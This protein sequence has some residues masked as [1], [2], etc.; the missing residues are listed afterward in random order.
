MYNTTLNTANSGTSITLE[1]KTA[2]REGETLEMKLARIMDTNA[3]SD[4]IEVPLIYT[5][6]SEGVI[7]MY[8][9]RYDKFEGLIEAKDALTSTRITEVVEKK[10]EDLK[11]QQEAAEGNDRLDQEK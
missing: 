5:E 3:I 7:N 1:D 11:K 6:K 2:V 10:K 4:E 8:N 9:I